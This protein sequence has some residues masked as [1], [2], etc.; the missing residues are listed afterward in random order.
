M[1]LQNMICLENINKHA[2]NK[3]SKPRS[4]TRARRAVVDSHDYMDTV[5]KSS[6]CPGDLQVP[7]TGRACNLQLGPDT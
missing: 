4:E 6:G 2:N 1:V 3:T 5:E 7:A